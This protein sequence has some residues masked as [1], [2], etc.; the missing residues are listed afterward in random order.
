[1]AEAAPRLLFVLPGPAQT[2]TG[3]Y[4]YDRRIAAG[5]RA[6]GWTVDVHPLPAE[7]PFPGERARRAAAE[8]LAA[9]DDDAL[10]LVDGLA[11][12][13]L[14]GLAREHARR[15]RLVA[16]V[17]HPLHL[18]SGLTPDRQRALFESER[19][20]LACARAVVVTGEDTARQMRTSALVSH[21]P[22]VVPPGV[23]RHAPR[24]PSRAAHTR[25][26][27][28]ATLTPRKDPLTLLEALAGLRALP[29]EL[30][31]IGS[32]AADAPTVAAVRA[33]IDRLGLGERVRLEGEVGPEALA[34]IRRDSDLFVQSS[35]YEGYGMALAE[36]I[37]QGL[38]AVATRTGAAAVLVGEQAGRL[39]PPG[40]AA[41]L[42]AAL[43]ELMGDVARR[44]ACAAAALAR[45]ADLP[46]WEEASAA[47]AG[48]LARTAGP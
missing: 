2:L 40:D 42:R 27:W 23:E 39:V 16:L 37:G 19:D 38:P 46:R 4:H 48:V 10:V 47:M 7:F 17:H 41:A 11:F 35:L 31:C 5:L 15:L 44:E 29:W 33:A 36:A 26:L 12:G 3:G 30:R 8:C 32:L 20:A 24:P 6:L 21:D 43:G 9:I 22:V 18:E 28:V 14:P 34:V 25:L 45:A 13:A 1:M